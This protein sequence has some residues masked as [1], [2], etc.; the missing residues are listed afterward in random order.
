MCGATLTNSLPESGGTSHASLE[1]LAVLAIEYDATFVVGDASITDAF[2][3]FR[4]LDEELD[5]FFLENGFRTDECSSNLAFRSYI[6][7]GIDDDGG[8][9]SITES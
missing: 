7:S 4:F 9:I 2:S 6:I 5:L 8:K 3:L 1:G